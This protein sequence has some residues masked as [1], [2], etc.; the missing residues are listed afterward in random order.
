VH[1]CRLWLRL[2]CPDAVGW[3]Y[4][5]IELPVPPVPRETL[6]G[7]LFGPAPILYSEG[8]C[9]FNAEYVLDVVWDVQPR[10]WVVN[11]PEHS[12]SHPWDVVVPRLYADW[13]IS[14][15]GPSRKEPASPAPPPARDPNTP[16]KDIISAEKYG[17]KRSIWPARVDRALSLLSDEP[18]GRV[19][20]R[21]LRGVKAADVRKLT[22]GN[23]RV[24][25]TLLEL[26]L[27]EKD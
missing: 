10:R 13:T 24:I 23:K 18:D 26:G 6:L 9:A 14:A 8:S 15:S 11:L 25:G 17:G 7:G 2:D 1:P 16:I 3:L 12:V 4:R 19:L 22:G 21:H 27:I 5:D 20:V